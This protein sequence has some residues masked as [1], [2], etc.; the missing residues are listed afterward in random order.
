FHTFTSYFSA[1]VLLLYE[2]IT[3]L[4]QEVDVIWC[5]KWTAITWLYALTR[6]SV[7]LQQIE[8]FTP[9]WNFTVRIH[10]N[11]SLNLKILNTVFLMGV[12]VCPGFSALRVYALLDGKYL[13]A[14]I[15][16]LLNL[17][18]FASNLVPVSLITRVAVIIG[19]ILVLVTTWSQTA[20]SY[21]EARRLNIRAPLVTMLFRDGAMQDHVCSI[22]VIY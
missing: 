4:S 6:Y 3:T 16:F 1:S 2:S 17:A 18:P 11:R 19:D 5:R 14:S 12:E 10:S 8:T 7:V 22:L 15:V 20:R 21:Q 9:V 13:M